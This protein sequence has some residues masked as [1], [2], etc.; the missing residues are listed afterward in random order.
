MNPTRR[1]F[2]QGA[3][4]LTLLPYQARAQIALGAARIDTLSD[5]HL[6]L[7]GAFYLGDAPKAEAAA[8]LDHYG[9]G[10]AEFRPDC[11]VTL[12]RDGAD[13]VLFDLGAGPDFMPTAGKLH[14]TLA[15]L[16]VAPEAVT[17]VVFT[18]AHPD[19]LWGLLDEFDEPRFA[20]ARYLIGR[21][22]W[23]FWTDPGTVDSIGPERTTF[24]VG[25]ARRLAALEDRIEL[26]DDGA[27][28]LSGV[29]A[30]ATPG[31]TPGHMSFEVR[32][33]S[34]SV[35]VLGDCIGNHHIAFERPG[36]H[37]G[38]DQDP[39]RAA[40][41]RLG[42]L[43]QLAAEQMRLIGYH[44]PGPGLGRA[45]RRDGSYRFVAEAS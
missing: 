28:V 18:H 10:T 25:A 9:L 22:E 42:L 20:N 2:L 17:A 13:T 44:L 43:D 32:R 24:A 8:I 11:N 40:A 41:T 38:T 19:H 5:G 36:W 12:L 4:A 23:E 26:F 33:G 27:E 6:V 1:Q 21:T 3:A 30:R 16:D 14:E 34:D 45:E 37:S 39:P 31:H 35:M 15:A 29:A 7:P